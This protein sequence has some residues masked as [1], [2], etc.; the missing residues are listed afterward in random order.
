[1][2]RKYSAIDLSTYII[3][4]ANENKKPITNLYL[5]KILYYIQAAQLVEKGET[6]FDEKIMAWKYGPVIEDV[7]FT[8]SPFGSSVIN[9]ANIINDS[10]E[11]DE[12]TKRRINKVVDEKMKIPAWKL[13]RQTHNE[14]PWIDATSNGKYLN[15]E[16]T[17]ESIRIYFSKQNTN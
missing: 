3:K 13:V 7:Y 8:F 9:S 4:Y 11:I 14:D 5:Q 10:I 12:D 6:I 1:M 15:D 16:I 17:I 2:S